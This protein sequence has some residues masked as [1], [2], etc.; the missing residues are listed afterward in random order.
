VEL[1]EIEAALSTHPGVKDAV[2]LARE[3]APSRAGDT[4][5][6]GSLRLA[7]FVVPTA[8][9]A[10]AAPSLRQYLEERLPEAWVPSWIT[11][12]DAL[13]LTPNGKVDRQ[14]LLAVG[15]EADEGEAHVAP[16]TPVEEV[17]ASVWADVFE[18][19]QVGIHDRFADL[20]G[21]SLLAIQIIA[22]QRRLPGR[23]AAPGEGK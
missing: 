8:P 1:G 14:A 20:G 21:H 9:G 11:L 16:R 7:A 2:V 18:R 12:I 19:D 6:S 10:A 15:A 17:L 5:A 22:R 13:P 4:P 3:D 23:G